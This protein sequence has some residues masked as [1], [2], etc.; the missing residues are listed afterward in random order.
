[1]KEGKLFLFREL[2]SVKQC[3]AVK[4]IIFHIS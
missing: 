4:I 1:M 3:S 2:Y